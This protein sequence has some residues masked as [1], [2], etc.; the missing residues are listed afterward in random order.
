[1]IRMKIFNYSLGIMF[2]ALLT[3]SILGFALKDKL[4]EKGI[5]Q[6]NNIAAEA[7]ENS[8]ESLEQLK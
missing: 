5:W 8:K 1:M 2:V 4:V 7:Q 3:A 6:I